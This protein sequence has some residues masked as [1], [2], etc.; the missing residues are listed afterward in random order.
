MKM[1]NNLSYFKEIKKQDGKKENFLFE[2]KHRHKI[3]KDC[4]I[5]TEK[6]TRTHTLAH[7][8]SN[9]KGNIKC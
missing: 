1:K 9:T 4:Y 2:F 5:F 8:K 3:V 6:F 7:K